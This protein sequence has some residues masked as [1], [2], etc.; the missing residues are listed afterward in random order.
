[1]TDMFD[2][3]T[4]ISSAIECLQIFIQPN[5]LEHNEAKAYPDIELDLEPL[6]DYLMDLLMLPFAFPPPPTG[7]SSEAMLSEIEEM[8][9]ILQSRCFLI[10]NRILM[11]VDGDKESVTFDSETIASRVLSLLGPLLTYREMFYHFKF[12]K[13]FSSF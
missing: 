9:D 13:R 5:F 7:E 3:K 8:H 10:Q 1:M 4:G 12:H 2:L 11:E 6:C